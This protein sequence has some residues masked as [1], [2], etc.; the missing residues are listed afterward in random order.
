M[1][2]VKKSFIK[3]VVLLVLS[4][5]I[6]S[7]LINLF[8]EVFHS[9]LYNSEHMLNIKY[10]LV[11]LLIASLKDGLIILGMYA[12]VAFLWRDIFWLKRIN[13]IKISLFVFLGLSIATWIEYR[14]VFLMNKWEYSSSMLTIFGIG[15]TPLVQLSLTG[16]ISIWLTKKLLYKGLIE[17]IS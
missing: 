9:L 3:E 6:M 15:F 8:W 17:K 14:A 16:I 12:F 13:T 1:K 10:Y 4:L 11:M 7:F 5:F 2:Y